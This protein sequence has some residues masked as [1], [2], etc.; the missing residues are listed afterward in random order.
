MSTR[1]TKDALETV[2]P[3]PLTVLTQTAAHWVMR[4][5]LD[6]L[7]R[8]GYAG[9]SEAHLALLGNLDCGTT[10]SAAIGQRMGISR[11]A[12]YRTVREMQALG[13]LRL[14]EDPE[15]GN[16]KLVVMTADGEKLA[17]RARAILAGLEQS[18][19]RRIGADRY[20]QFRAAL[21]AEW[22]PAE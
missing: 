18:L 7:H 10:K 1:F 2:P 5:V 9:I 17:L 16:Q 8:A 15:R 11:Q 22:G 6:G 14:E 19:C 21:E 13:L 20:A 4:G 12:I 3:A